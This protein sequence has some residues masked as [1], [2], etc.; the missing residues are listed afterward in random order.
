MY[1]TLITTKIRKQLS[2]ATKVFGLFL[3]SL[4]LVSFYSVSCILYNCIRFLILVSPRVEGFRQ[5]SVSLF[6]K[7]QDHEQELYDYRYS[8]SICR[9]NSVNYQ[10]NW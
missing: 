5:K 7:N 1:L 10:S 8:D 6:K 2:I 3:H 4:V 9:N